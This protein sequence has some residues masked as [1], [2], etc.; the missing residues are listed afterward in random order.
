MGAV[1]LSAVEIPAGGIV[2]I[3]LGCI[4]AGI[5]IACVAVLAIY[6][7][8]LKRKIDRS[9]QL[10][11]KMVEEAIVEAKKLRKD[12]VAEGKEG[13]QRVREREARA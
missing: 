6:H 5:L 9:K 12:A 11:S 2:G 10:A 13:T 7:F 3:V 1:I 4:V 8:G